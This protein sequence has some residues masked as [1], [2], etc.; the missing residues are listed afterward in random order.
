MSMIWSALDALTPESTI[1]VD[2]MIN[3]QGRQGKGIDHG[4][5]QGCRIDQ[6]PAQQR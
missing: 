6:I 2:V 1:Q 4:G 3:Q 5:E